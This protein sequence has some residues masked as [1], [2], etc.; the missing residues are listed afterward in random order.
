MPER[1]SE[2]LHDEATA[3]DVPHAPVGDVLARGR[4]LR[5]RRRAVTVLGATAAVA[6]LAVGVT[7][8]PEPGSEGRGEELSPAAE[9]LRGW[10]VGSGSAVLLG[11]GRTASVDGTVKSVYYTSAGVLVRTGADATTDAPD[12]AYSLVTE[13]ATVTDFALELGDRVPGTDPGL[14]YLAYAEPTG[15][16]DRWTVVLRDV[17]SGEVAHEVPVSGAFTWGGWVAPPVSLSGDHVYVGMDGA[18][19]DVHWPTGEVTRSEVL[20]ASTMP[21]VAGGREVLGD[22][23]EAQ[24]VVDVQTGKVLLRVPATDASLV[25]SPDGRHALLRPMSMCDDSGTCTFEQDTT[26]VYDVTTG[27]ATTVDLAGTAMGWTPQ[28]DLL[29]VDEDSVDVCDPSTG[30]CTPTP[31]EVDGRGLRLGGSLYEA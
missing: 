30:E 22:S 3:L 5:R 31:L 18:T 12:S 24:R 2:L 19:L 15:A 13:D 16:P 23:G 7:L 11:N 14:P 8:L 1:I 6:A 17:R 25:L 26:E 4:G 29:R 9:A 10:A 20:P 21:V 27:S 28:G